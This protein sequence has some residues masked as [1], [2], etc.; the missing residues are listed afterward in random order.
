MEYTFDGV[1][2]EYVPELSEASHEAAIEA[3][4]NVL[5]DGSAE[6]IDVRGGFLYERKGEFSMD[7]LGVER[8]RSYGSSS[9]DVVLQVT[10]RVSERNVHEFVT[11]AIA[12]RTAAD[13]RRREQERTAIDAQIE[14]L[15]AKRAAI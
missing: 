5:Q 14:A 11:Q 4:V 13:E 12:D 1:P 9:D 15:Q 2:S 10:V 6:A 8:N 7:R 3:L